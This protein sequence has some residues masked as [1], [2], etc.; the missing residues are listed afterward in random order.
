MTQEQALQ[1][2]TVLPAEMLGMEIGTLLLAQHHWG[3]QALRRF[4]RTIPGP[5]V[6]ETRR[7]GSLTERQRREITEALMRYG[8]GRQAA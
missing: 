8:R 1:S 7:I 5:R 3:Y 4:M 6:T 2:A